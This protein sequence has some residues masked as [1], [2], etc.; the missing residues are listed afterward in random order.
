MIKKIFCI[1]D[2][3]I[4][5]S[6]EHRPYSEMLKQAIA[7]VYKQTKTM[8]R[9]DFRIVVVG[10]IFHNKIRT[11]NE[12]IETFHM[13]L[14]YLNAIGK[15]YIIAGNHD[16][17]ENNLDRL[18]SISPTFGIKD[19]YPNVVYLDKELEYK[20]G[21]FVDD[22]VTFALYSIFDSFSRPSGLEETIEENPNNKV[23][24]LYH[25]DM[26]GTV[27]DAGRC[28][29]NGINPLVFNGCSIVIAGHI[30]KYQQLTK[31]NI[32]I[33][34]CGSLLQQNSGENISKHGFV[35]L[36]VDTLEHNL[37]EVTNNYKIYKF[38]LS[39]YDDVETDSERLINS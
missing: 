5:N 33:V 3:H 39:S 35:T 1:A 9:D 8:D 32:Q 28:S 25:G 23:I 36:D 27:T 31:N 20:S 11:S 30:H 6:E 21:C 14:N 10:D 17:L 22:N 2:V 37:T 15:T 34:Y 26:A 13:M 16:M 19:V 38:K 12:A 7:E 18:D 29:E 24:A 4:P